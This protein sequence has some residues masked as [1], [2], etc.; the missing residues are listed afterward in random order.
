LAANYNIQCHIL[1]VGV[2]GT[3]NTENSSLTTHLFFF[4]LLHSPVG[5]SLVRIQQQSANAFRLHFPLYLLILA[6]VL[7]E[8]FAITIVEG[9]HV[10]QEKTPHGNEENE[11]SVT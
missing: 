2:Y 4:C 10:F 1:N 3:Q 7:V 8:P 9:C 11:V 5:V 6:N